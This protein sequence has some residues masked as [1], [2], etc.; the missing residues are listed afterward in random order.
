MKKWVIFPLSLIG[1]IL[2][3]IFY[4]SSPTQSYRQPS[5]P[6]FSEAD[7]D[8][9]NDH[10]RHHYYEGFA[11]LKNYY[12][13]LENL[14]NPI[15]TPLILVTGLED[16]TENWW[17]TAKAAFDKGFRHVYII[18]LRGQGRSERVE[19]NSNQSIHINDFDSYVEDIIRAHRAIEKDYGVPNDSPFLIAHS[20]GTLVYTASLSRIRAEIPQWEPSKLSY[21]APLV[22]PKV[23][24]LLNNPVVKPLLK[25]VSMLGQR[26]GRT[27]LGRRFS[28]LSFE[29]NKVTTD[30][31]RF[32]WSEKIRLAENQ[33]SS[34]VSLLWA[35]ETFPVADAL[36][37]NDYQPIVQPCLVLKAGNDLVVDNEW[38]IENDHFVFEMIPEAKHA[39]HL[40]R[41]EIF[42]SVVE[43]TFQ[44]FMNR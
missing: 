21:W 44:F 18:E 19:G 31:N 22:Q 11:G 25:G 30:P 14:D 12:A 20:T 5:T 17:D 10:L 28:P 40:E 33:N 36:L 1:L 41:P 15:E 38:H 13:K 35:L 6:P 39:L 32:E 8:F 16:I 23:S 37:A 9:Q 43:S 24:P 3:A 2:G 4:L 7:L 29:E 34:G 26:M 27:V 42:D